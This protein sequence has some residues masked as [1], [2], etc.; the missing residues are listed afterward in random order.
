ML[1]SKIQ[2]KLQKELNRAFFY[3]RVLGLAKDYGLPVNHLNK[4]YE[5]YDML[6]DCGMQ[7]NM[8]P[9]WDD[10]K[11]KKAY[12]FIRRLNDRLLEDESEA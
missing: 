2:I 1:D 9:R 12:D 10:A 6:L 11:E 7:Y 5:F 4:Q 3:M 8:Y